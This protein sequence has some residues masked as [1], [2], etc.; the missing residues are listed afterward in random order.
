MKKRICSVAIIC[1]MLVALSACTS[2]NKPAPESTA[3]ATTTTTVT[4]EVDVVNEAAEEAAAESHGSDENNGRTLYDDFKG[5][6]CKQVIDQLEQWHNDGI[7][8]AYF[9]EVSAGNGTSG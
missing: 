8:L 2:T 7:K 3:A 9:V 1:A 6:T 5:K 4:N